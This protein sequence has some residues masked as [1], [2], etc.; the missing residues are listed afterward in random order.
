MQIR[1]LDLDLV[2]DALDQEVLRQDRGGK[3]V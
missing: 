1:D 3:L 2:G